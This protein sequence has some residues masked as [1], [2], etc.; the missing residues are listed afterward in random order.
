VCCRNE[1]IAFFVCMKTTVN[2]SLLL[3]NTHRHMVADDHMPLLWQIL[4]ALPPHLDAQELV[5]HCKGTQFP[6][7]FPLTSLHFTCI[8]VPS[9][10]LSL[11]VSDVGMLHMHP[12]IEHGINSRP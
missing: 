10:I 3:C 5:E 11:I 4:L 12:A 1:H 2:A 9:T 6:L 7:N 8:A